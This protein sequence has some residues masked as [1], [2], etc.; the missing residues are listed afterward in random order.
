MSDALQTLV[1]IPLSVWIGVGVV[2]ASFAA[3]ALFRPSPLQHRVDRL[4]HTST[5][6]VVKSS[7]NE[8]LTRLVAQLATALRLR[9][10]VSDPA[11]AMRLRMAG[12]ETKSAVEV[13][14]LVRLLLPVL[15]FGFSWLYL[16]ASAD[17]ESK[18]S[19]A[20]L[21]AAMVGLIG[22]FL[23]AVYLKNRIDKRRTAIERAWPDALDLLVL[24]VE[25]GLP[26]DAAF[27]RVADEIGKAA[28]IL[29]QELKITVA[30]MVL[31]PS[32]REAYENLAMRT[33]TVMVRRVAAALVH[34]EEYGGAIAS[35]LRT[36][37]RE[38][39][40]IRM[41]EAERRAAGLPPLM[42]VPMILF[43]MPGLFAI[44][45]TPTLIAI[46]GGE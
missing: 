45:L 40:H 23:P 5:T 28:P 4:F 34:V 20:L 21:I 36:Q 43:F 29:A 8:R 19:V 9:D 32:R 42:T 30:E 22:L 16:R 14:V 24:T 6:S 10:A 11:L 35:A 15:L 44:I 12:F 2:I 13:Y 37:A 3:F 31:L 27:S 38:S 17:A 7:P 18:A 26:L 25:A 39:R 41:G 46:F 1:T 33:D